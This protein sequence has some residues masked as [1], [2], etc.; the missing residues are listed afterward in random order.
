M[1]ACNIELGVSELIWWI[2]SVTSF[3]SHDLCHLLRQSAMM[4][5]TAFDSHDARDAC[6]QIY[7]EPWRELCSQD[8]AH[9]G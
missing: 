7:G 2:H 6:S 9:G 5:V 1:H 8:R 4:Y 3:D